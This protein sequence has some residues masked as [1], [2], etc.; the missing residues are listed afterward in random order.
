MKC[1]LYS[2]P[3]LFLTVFA[4]AQRSISY[5]SF[6]PPANIVQNEVFLK[7]NIDS[8]SHNDTSS[9]ADKEGRELTGSL[10]LGAADKANINIDT[11]TVIS[12]SATDKSVENFYADNFIKI[13]STGTNK[14]IVNKYIAIG[15]PNACAGDTTCNTIFISSGKMK[16]V[17][18]NISNNSDMDIN[19]YVSSLATI[20]NIRITPENGNNGANFMSDIPSGYKLVWCNMRLL[21]TEVCRKYLV[22]L[23][24]NSTAVSQCSGTTFCRVPQD[25]N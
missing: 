9:L 15:N 8:F 2:F 1:V 7:Q 16:S 23:P 5:I 22:A 4:Q 17:L 20:R 12:D 13:I 19:G 18:D 3:F 6:F 11:M 24:K 21:G 25:G 14:G 10:I